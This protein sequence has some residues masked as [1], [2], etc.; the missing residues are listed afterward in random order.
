MA[1]S[2]QRHKHHGHPQPPQHLHTQ[3]HKPKRKAAVMMA[4]FIGLV[5]IIIGALA[6]GMDVIWT[7]AS[8]AL[9]VAGGALIG[10]GIDRSIEKK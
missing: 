7:L 9:G 10:H 3:A 1:Q 2:R 8:G 4:L 6:S 5:G